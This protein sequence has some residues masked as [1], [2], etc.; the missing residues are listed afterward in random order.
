MRRTL[1]VVLALI[2]AVGLLAPPVMAQAP[3]PKVTINGLFD[4]SAS[5]SKN[6]A[7]VDLTNAR[8]QFSYTRER[9]RIDII[10]EVGK[11]K[12]VWGLELDF[13]NGQSSAAAPGNSASFDL[14]TDVA[15]VV[16]TKWLYIETPLSGAGSILP[17]IPVVST[18]RAGAQPF[19]GHEYKFGLIAGGDFPGVAVETKWTPNISSTLTYVQVREAL[20]RT[21]STTARQAESYAWLLSAE[22]APMKG[23]TVKPT[24][25]YKNGDGGNPGGA[26][27]GADDLGYEAK[28]GFVYT[29]SGV[30]ASHKTHVHTIGAEAKWAMGPLRIEPS[31]FWQ[32]GKQ[33]VSPVLVNNQVKNDV[34]VHSWIFDGIAGYRL[35][36]LDL[37]TRFM[38]TP[39]QDTQHMVRNGSDIAY[40]QTPV[41]SGFAYMTGWTELQTSQVEYNNAL[42]TGCPGCTLRQN[43]SYD[44]YGR[45][46]WAVKADYTLTP[47]L[48]FYGIVNASWTDKDVD[49]TQIIGAT[50]SVAS[51]TGSQIRGENNYLGTELDLGMTWRFAPNVALDLVWA[52]MWTGSAFDQSTNATN[53]AA[54][55]VND[56]K[57]VYKAVSRIRFTF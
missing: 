5:I 22:V 44:K 16:E 28:D 38:Y 32:F 34:D 1:V 24:Y 55:V 23:L 6:W 41:N 53:Q 9:G 13:N 36:P 43:P 49:K 42:I 2:A 19:K 14:D 18:L 54:G 26:A 10:G 46:M 57:D 29:V 50:G 11:S 40:F 35:G 21:V 25:V 39:G 17:F 37:S 12:G 27:T 51:G 3:A 47:A 4:F 56:S 45:I 52:Y 31:I 7:D 15:G 20:F 8:D 30:P 33:G 48:N